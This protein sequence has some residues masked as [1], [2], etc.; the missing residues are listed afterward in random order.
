MLHIIFLS[1]KAG[2][3]KSTYALALLDY[4][5]NEGCIPFIINFADYIKF[6]ATH[7]YNWNGKKDIKGRDLLQKIGKLMREYDRDLIINELIERIELMCQD[8]TNN[9]E[10]VCIISDTRF[11]NEIK[12][13]SDYFMNDKRLSSFT[14]EVLRLTRTFDSE[15]TMEQQLDGTEL[16]ISDYL[17]DYEVSL[18]E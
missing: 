11:D 9:K 1:G 12:R 5:K 16:G 18:D 14:T 6:V 2:V 3:G 4:Y 15:L 17:I 10:Y 13:I 8:F 7:F